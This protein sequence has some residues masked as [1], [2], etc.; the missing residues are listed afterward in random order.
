MSRSLTTLIDLTFDFEALSQKYVIYKASL[1]KS[2][3]KVDYA[4]QLSLVERSSTPKA[5]IRHSGY[6]WVLRDKQDKAKPE[7]AYIAFERVKFEDCDLLLLGRLFVR[8]L[9]KVAPSTFFSGLGDTF[10]FVESDKFFEHTVYKCLKFDLKESVRFNSLFISMDGTTFSP[11]ET[12]YKPAGYIEKQA[13][14]EFDMESGLLRRNPK[15]KLI[16]HSPGKKKF[17]TNAIDI[18]GQEPI[19]LQKTKTGAIYQFVE[20]MNK[21]FSGCL[22]LQLKPIEASW[23]EH[24]KKRDVEKVYQ[25]I[26]QVIDDAGGLQVANASLKDD[27]FEKLKSHQWP[28][29]VEFVEAVDIDARKPLL[30]VLDSAEDYEKAG[31]PDPKSG[32]YSSDRVTQSIYNSTI[33]SVRPK[34]KGNELSPIIDAVVK[35]M[36]IKQECLKRQFLIQELQ[37]SY[38]F[39]ERE[40]PKYRDQ[41]PIFHI[42][43]CDNGTFLY[44]EQDEFYFDE[45]DIELPEKQR[46][47]ETLNYVIDMAQHPPQICTIVHEEIAAIPD[48]AN[49]FEVLDHLKSSNQHGISRDFIDQFLSDSAYLHDPIS[50]KLISM[51][52]QHP[53]QNEFYKE[54]LKTAKIGYRSTAEQALVDGY[55]EETGVM[56]NYS[57]KGE[58]N[59]YLEALTGHFYDAEHSVYFVGSEKGGFKFH[60]GHFNHLRYLEGPE[61]LKQRCLELTQSYFVRNKLAT[62][63]PF[64]FKYLSECRDRKKYTKE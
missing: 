25:R 11:I 39:V 17:T 44:E 31:L 16:V 13:K 12:A 64:P 14:F 36:A 32:F 61:D 46:Y 53:L 50:G 59:E 51:L 22:S 42:L 20:L 48:A 45:L 57:L 43:K 18:S 29:Q 5:L 60:R 19:S 54:D 28:V 56:L 3:G 62:V 26:Y 1:D 10:L 15:G 21:H 8:A 30:V 6:Y 9:G 47:F 35:E 49:L 4:K 63:R 27:G 24:Y 52:E 58:N 7:S 38:W 40:E 23:R 34:A 37:G 33:T 41:E 2:M 55:F